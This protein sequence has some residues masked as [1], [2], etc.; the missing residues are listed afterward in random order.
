[1]QRPGQRSAIGSH[2]PHLHMRVG[3]I[4]VLGDVD[5]VAQRD[6]AAAQPNGG[7]IDRGHHRNS[8]PRHAQHDLAPVRDGLGPQV[9]V[10][11]QLLEIP[12]SPPAE[13]ALPAPVITA[14]RAV[15]VVG[16]SLP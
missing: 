5:D 13:N 12:K 15:A 3:E 10:V 7:A 2:Q 14:A 6:Q 8:A 9:G 4:G 11:R 16:Q 1:M